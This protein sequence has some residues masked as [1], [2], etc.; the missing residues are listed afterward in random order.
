MFCVKK[1]YKYPYKK[2]DVL[3]IKWVFYT[4]SNMMLIFHFMIIMLK[5]PILKVDLSRFI[6]KLHLLLSDVQYKNGLQVDKMW[7]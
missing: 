6:K 5:D 1:N 7:I 2:I 4:M 3:Q